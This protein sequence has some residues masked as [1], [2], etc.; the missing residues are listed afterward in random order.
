MTK[1]SEHIDRNAFNNDKKSQ[2]RHQ[3][4]DRH[5]HRGQHLRLDPR[6]PIQMCIVT[7]TP[8]LSSPDNTTDLTN[9]S[10]GFN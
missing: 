2:F 10:L 7:A 1:L 9:E 4:Q 6:V 3:H 5:Q 8:L